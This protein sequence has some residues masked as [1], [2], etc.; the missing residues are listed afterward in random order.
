MLPAAQNLP[1]GTLLIR[2]DLLNHEANHGNFMKGLQ[3]IRYI[4]LLLFSILVAGQLQAQSFEN[5]VRL[6]MEEDF[7]KAVEVFAALQDDR[8]ALFAGKSAFALSDYK[9]AETYLKRAS[10]SSNPSISQEADYT[11]AMVYYSLGEYH[12]A[13][14]LLYQLSESHSN[15][16][17]QLFAERFYHQITEYLTGSQRIELLHQIDSSEIRFDLYRRGVDILPFQELEQVGKELLAMTSSRSVRDQIE[18]ALAIRSSTQSDDHHYPEVPDGTIYNIG[19]ILPVFPV[20]DPDYEIPRNLYLGI[21]LAAD[22][23]NSRNRNRKIRIR[24]K[25]THERNDSTVEAIE[26]LISEQASDAIIGPLF[27]EQAAAAAPI[28]DKH[29]VPLFIPLANSTRL[30]NEFDY[31]YQINPS[32]EAHARVM[33]DF[34]NEVLG[35]QRLGIIAESGTQGSQFARTFQ[36]RSEQHGAEITRFVEQNFAASG[37]DLTGVSA[38]FYGNDEEGIPASQAIYAPFTGQSSTT[39][40]NLLL[41][42]MEAS[43]YFMPILGSED[44][45]F[46]TI[47][48]FQ[49]QNLEIFYTE[50]AIAGS[51]VMSDEMSHFTQEYVTRFGSEPD[52]FST[53]GY[54]VGNYL[55]TALEKAGNPL[56][57]DRV[58][59]QEPIFE[60]LSIQI[61]MDENRVN[62]H[63]FIRPLTDKAQQLLDSL[64][65]GQ[66]P[67]ASEDSIEQF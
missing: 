14:P 28:S 22:E 36:R 42:D 26:S 25:N 56:Y 34:A 46:G 21:V 52:P 49:H 1:P 31:S 32:P 66:L 37:Y 8:S 4:A 61:D 64:Q 41:N 35:Y 6:Y 11:L 48:P 9:E 10:A 53:L 5:G 67:A 40:M 44:W 29:Q 57:L 23:F 12:L 7:E 59:E 43:G 2:R 3:S 62:R 17:V 27:S 58:I 51:E 18:R 16:G 33:A 45:K 20:D 24:F 19:V 54:D 60:G 50:A 65:G 38:G 47:T 15:T 30:S 55:F 39:M 63:L 13:L